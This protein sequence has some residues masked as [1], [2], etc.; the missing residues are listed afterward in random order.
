MI[1]TALMGNPFVDAAVCAI[2]EWLGIDDPEEID[3]QYLQQLVA[4]VAPLMQSET[5]WKNLHSIYPNS[6]LVNPSFKNQN[7]VALLEDLCHDYLRQVEP[8]GSMGD[9]LGCGRRDSKKVRLKRQNIPLTGSGALL[10]F[11]PTFQEGVGYCAACALAVQFLPLGLVATSGRFL[12]MHANIWSAQRYWSRRCVED[13]QQ[14]YS[15]QEINGCYNPGYFKA[16]NA[17]FFMAKEMISYE[18][19]NDLENLSLTIYDFSNYAQ[20]PKLDLYQI[21]SKVFNFLRYCYQRQFQSDWLQVVR[22]GYL[23][24]DWNKV[25]SEDDYKNKFNLVFEK[26][27]KQQ[28]ILGFF[29][30]RRARNVRA[31]WQLLSCYLQEVRQMELT[32]IEA[33]QKIGDSIAETIRQSDRDRRLK[34]LERSKSYAECRNV[35]RFLIQDRIAQGQPEP[36]FTLTEYMEYLFPNTGEEFTNW[37]ESRDLLLF[38]LYEQLHDWLIEKDYVSEA[39]EMEEDFM[40]EE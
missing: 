18:E 33:I 7:R 36:L 30:N 12:M 22:A 17:L 29:L 6:V 10:N 15:R 21:P 26:L 2:C 4:E 32:R 37:R 13:I 23:K 5:G 28:S 38:H 35:L 31:G 11:F 40:E 19:E 8:L 24:V 27:L 9:C 25:E 39:D 1:F 14:Q 34:Q 3:Q 16:K 20:D